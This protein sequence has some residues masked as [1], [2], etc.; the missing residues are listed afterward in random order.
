MRSKLDSEIYESERKYFK[1][2]NVN[3]VAKLIPNNDKF[4]SY[5]LAY[6]SEIIVCTLTSL[7]FEMFGSGKKVLFGASGNDFYLARKWKAVKNFEKLPSYVLLDELT[8]EGVSVKLRELLV[9]DNEKYLNDT[10]SASVYYM[11]HRNGIY[12]DDIVKKKIA[13]YLTHFRE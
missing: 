13:S 12:A 11:N 2:L 9:M 3:N 7:G 6:H 10:V 4:G 5:D 1:D 8:L